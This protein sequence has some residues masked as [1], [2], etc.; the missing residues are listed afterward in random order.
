MITAEEPSLGKAAR[1]RLLWS[2]GLGDIGTGM[3]ATQLG[4]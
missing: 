3:A 4:F 2:Y 1:R